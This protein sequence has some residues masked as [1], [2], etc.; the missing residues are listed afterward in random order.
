MRGN[1]VCYD[2]GLFNDGSS[3]HEPFR[4]ERVA[5]DMR[6][7]REE[8]HGS[9]VR[10]TGGSVDR[11]NLAATHAAAV[12]LEVWLCPFTNGLTDDELLATLA[13]CAEHAE[14]LR[15]GGADV[16]LVTGSEI[17][18]MNVGY[19]PGATF[20]NRSTALAGPDRAELLATI[21]PKV[22]AFLARRSRPCG[23]GS[24]VTSATPRC[25]SRVSTGY[26]ST[27]SRPMP[28]TDGPRSRISS[29]R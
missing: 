26:R 15:R 25:R 10:I 20:V 1:G 18:V 8:L 24:T 6:V 11:L 12:G 5:R 2:T 27:M 21:P 22:N 28:V 23:V 7:I 4:P 14:G 9:A 29:R 3:T 13:T 19:L 17:S 16:V